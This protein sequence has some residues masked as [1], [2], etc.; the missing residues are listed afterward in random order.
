[1]DSKILNF[2]DAM[3]LAKIISKYFTVEQVGKLN[4]EEFGYKLFDFLAE[5]EIKEI[6]HLLLGDH[7][8]TTPKEIIFESVNTIIKNDILNLLNSY[9]QLGYK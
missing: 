9:K 2:V 3:K 8:L 1:M 4:G 5:E 6:I 7:K